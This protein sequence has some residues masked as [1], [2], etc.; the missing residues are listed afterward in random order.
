MS[1]GDSGRS[2]TSSSLATAADGATLLR[3]TSAPHAIELTGANGKFQTVVTD[4]AAGTYGLGLR[5]LGQRI[6][7]IRFS[8]C[9]W[10]CGRRC[11]QRR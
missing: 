3:G 4:R 9:C 11:D 10:R 7:R 6:R 5:Y 8:F 1:Q 2:L